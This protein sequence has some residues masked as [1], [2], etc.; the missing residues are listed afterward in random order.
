MMLPLWTRV[1]LGRSLADGVFDGGGDESLGAFLADGLEA[2]SAGI[3]EADLFEPVREVLLHERGE[4]GGVLGAG[5][6]F[7]AGVD[8]LGVL[9][10]DD[11]VAR[12]W[13]P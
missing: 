12:G 8:V 3:G 10:E 13:V 6:V 4:F 2:E 11:H 9:A 5:L 7:D 1:T